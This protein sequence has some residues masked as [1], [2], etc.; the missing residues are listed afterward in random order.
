MADM[1]DTAS[2]ADIRRDTE[3]TEVRQMGR[4]TE[5]TEVRQMGRD[6]EDTAS[7]ADIRRDME[8]TGSTA[9]GAGH[10]RY[11]K[12]GGCSEQTAQDRM[13]RLAPADQAYARQCQL[14]PASGIRGRSKPAPTRHPPSEGAPSGM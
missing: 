7:T 1:A 6:T 2:T 11:R 12:Y 14:A 10:G 9:D 8:D 3:D 13:M 4:D 5:D